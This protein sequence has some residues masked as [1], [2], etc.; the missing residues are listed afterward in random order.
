MK[1]NGTSKTSS[2]QYVADISG[3]IQRA[4]ITPVTTKPKTIKKPQGSTLE[5]IAACFQGNT[6]TK[7]LPPSNGGKGNK[8]KT[9]ITTLTNTPARHISK[10][11]RSVSDTLTK[12]KYMMAQKIA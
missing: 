7:I 10:K 1:R 8:L 3:R 11:K 6:P 12:I 9:S 2:S 5:T 4:L